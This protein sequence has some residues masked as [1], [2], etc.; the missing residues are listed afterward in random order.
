MS[1][2]KV[3]NIKEIN[4]DNSKVNR[5]FSDKFINSSDIE[6]ILINNIPVVQSA[7]F[8]FQSEWAYNAYQSMK[9]LDKYLILVYLIQ[10]TLIHYSD[11]MVIISEETMYAQDTFEIDKINLRMSNQY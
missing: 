9:D 1:E 3:T 8:R 11:L 6:N 2:K 7:W 5:G 10:K 4:F